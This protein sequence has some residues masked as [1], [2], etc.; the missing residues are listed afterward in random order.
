MARQFRDQNGKGVKLFSRKADWQRQ[1]LMNSFGKD[2]FQREACLKFKFPVYIN[3]TDHD[4]NHFP[5]VEEYTSKA[6]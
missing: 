3:T 2:S 1:K 5:Y 4:G 6:A